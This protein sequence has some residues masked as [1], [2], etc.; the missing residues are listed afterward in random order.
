MDPYDFAATLLPKTKQDAVAEFW[1]AFLEDA[2]FLQKAFIDK[3]KDGIDS[4]LKSEA[5][6]KSIFDFVTM[7]CLFEEK[8]HKLC[9]TSSWFGNGLPLL[10]LI[11]RMAPDLP[12]WEVSYG[13]KAHDEGALFPFSYDN[14]FERFG[15]PLLL[16]DI[17]P[18]LNAD[19]RIDIMGIGGSAPDELMKQ[20]NRAASMI[21]AEEV[22]RD[23]VGY[24]E[25]RP[26]DVCDKASSEPNARLDPDT[27]LAEFQA[28]ISKVQALM[29]KVP[30]SERKLEDLNGEVI[31]LED[32]PPD[33]RRP[34]LE[35]MS[36]PEGLFAKGAINAPRFSS[37]CYSAF[38][39]WFLN[40]RVPVA[41]IPVEDRNQALSLLVVRLHEALVV[42]HLGGCAMHGVGREAIYIDVAVTD[43][44]HGVAVIEAALREIPFAASSTL[45]FMDIGL[46]DV[47]IPLSLNSSQQH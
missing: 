20:T 13:P 42:D 6:L 26:S 47:F 11:E 24:T 41:K 19:G 40:I 39:E 9:I 32:M 36:I 45:H 44:A 23:W 17:K 31:H 2:E 35:V 10:R 30:F 7:E 37:R 14:Y 28:E 34:D 27:F 21:L 5:L 3:D 18:N 4:A 1:E 43:V 8:G 16:E 12:G 22:R 25:S 38:G 29:A 33:H 15:H 46:E